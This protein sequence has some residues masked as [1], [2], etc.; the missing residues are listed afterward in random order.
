MQPK[1]VS[2]NSVVKKETHPILLC[3]YTHLFLLNIHVQSNLYTTNTG[4]KRSWLR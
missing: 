1:M 4:V 2:E 3:V